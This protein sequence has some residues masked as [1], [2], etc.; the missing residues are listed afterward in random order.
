MDYARG[1]R[2][3]GWLTRL[4]WPR[5]EVSFTPFALV[6]LVVLLVAWLMPFMA[7]VRD[8]SHFPAWTRDQLAAVC[9]TIRNVES[10]SKVASCPATTLPELVD[11]IAASDVGTPGVLGIDLRKRMIYDY[12]DQ[13]IHLIL[14][15]GKLAALGSA[16]ED[17]VWNDGRGDD[18][19]VPLESPGQ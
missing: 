9:T 18:I 12:W 2:R 15:E 1:P 13:P 19:V 14:R 8:R 17:G 11:W 4:F 16:G 7:K 6:M 5:V 10:E 3:V